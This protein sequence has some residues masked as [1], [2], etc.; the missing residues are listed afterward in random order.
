[1]IAPDEALC[2]VFRS[3]WCSG[4]AAAASAVV[5]HP[6]ATDARPKSDNT[7]A[8]ADDAPCGPPAHPYPGCGWI[9]QSAAHRADGPQPWRARAWEFAAS[10]QVE[11]L[12]LA[13]YH[14][15]A[16]LL[17]G[18]F[19]VLMSDLDGAAKV[20]SA[21][22]HSAMERPSISV[23]Q[24]LL[25]VALTA[26]AFGSV[27]MLVSLSRSRYPGRPLRPPQAPPGQRLP[28]PTDA[29]GRLPQRGALVRPQ[30]PPARPRRAHARAR[31]GCRPGRPVR[32]GG[33]SAGVGAGGV[34]GKE[35]LVDGPR[36]PEVSEW[37]RGLRVAVTEPSNEGTG[38]GACGLKRTTSHCFWMLWLQLLMREML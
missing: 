9:G 13:R 10:K 26:G 15:A 21:Q 34:R 25:L 24:M 28:L 20:Q 23:L 3:V 35:V 29:W 18:G 7:G 11:R 19:N 4:D 38:G 31:C 2:D 1:M 14:V 36:R 32:A 8:N 17:R 22:T 12:W 30:R 5:T 6:Y 37:V 16:Q 27:S 33:V